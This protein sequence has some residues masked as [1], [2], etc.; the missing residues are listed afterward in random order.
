[1]PAAREE[2]PRAC[3]NGALTIRPTMSNATAATAPQTI[4]GAEVVGSIFVELANA[5]YTPA[6][7]TE[8]S[9]LKERKKPGL[10]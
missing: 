8:Q 3:I 6:I 10:H 5:G 4:H 9:R 1:M 7:L 2:K